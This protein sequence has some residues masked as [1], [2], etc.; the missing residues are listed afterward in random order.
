MFRPKLELW[1]SSGQTESGDALTIFLWETEPSR[2]EVEQV[3]RDL[4]PYEFD[5]E[6][7]PGFVHFDIE[8]VY[9]GRK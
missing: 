3:Y 7:G 6:H 4:M 8:Q 9:W 1:A 5:E 2:E